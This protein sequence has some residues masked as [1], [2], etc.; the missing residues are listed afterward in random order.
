MNHQFVAMWDCNGLE[1]VCDI[2]EKQGQKI[3]NRISGR[4]EDPRIPN[5]M[6]LRLRAQFNSQ[7]HYE[8]YVFEANEGI[9]EQD[10]VD[11]FDAA[12]QQAADTIRELGHCV[13]SDRQ[14]KPAAIT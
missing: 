14:T 4:G 7:R 11:M 10:I 3:W 5:L 6:H 1:Y 8:I 13:Y 9:T 12:P 2:T